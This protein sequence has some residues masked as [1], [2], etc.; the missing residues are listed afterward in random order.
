MRNVTSTLREVI[1]PLCS[2]ET[3]PGVLH[4]VLQPSTQGGH[5]FV[6]AGPE[7][8]RADQRAVAP[9]LLQGQAGALQPGEEKAP[10]RPYS[11]FPVSERGIRESW[12]GTFCKDR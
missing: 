11:S 1:L 10:R 12:G 4:Q 7:G 3:P 5:G 2:H 6:G 8:D 9:P